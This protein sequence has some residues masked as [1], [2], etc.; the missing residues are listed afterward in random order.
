MPF[1]DHRMES[2]RIQFRAS[3]R[4]CHPHRRISTL[5]ILGTSLTL[6]ARADA[7]LVFVNMPVA[8]SPQSDLGDE[9]IQGEYNN[10]WKAFRTAVRKNTDSVNA[11]LAD[12]LHRA[13]EKGDLKLG[14]EWLKRKE[15]FASK[16]QVR[17]DGTEFGRNAWQTKYG[18]TYPQ[19]LASKLQVAQE[20]YAKA[21][22]DL[23]NAYAEFVK[24]LTVAKQLDMAQV[25]ADERSQVKVGDTP[26]SH[27]YTLDEDAFGFFAPSPN[28]SVLEDGDGFFFNAAARPNAWVVSN[29]AVAFPLRVEFQALVRKHRPFDIFPGIFATAREPDSSGVQL[30]WGTFANTRT[31]LSVFGESHNLRHD[32]IEPNRLYTIVFE[33]NKKRVLTVSIDDKQIYKGNLPPNALLEGSIKMGGGIGTVVYKSLIIESQQG[34]EP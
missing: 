34:L 17:W 1:R 12:Q 6:A 20:G 29:Q 28:V 5:L 26:R 15:A 7:D 14:L 16:G 24:N 31:T 2:S 10:A 33:V 25:I 18:D 21:I 27:S 11:I 19:E 13:T 23:D 4:W 22:D 9:D 32:A 3:L 30:C 8:C